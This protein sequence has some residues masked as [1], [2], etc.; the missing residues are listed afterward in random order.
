[1]ET[2]DF[3]EDKPMVEKYNID[4]IPAVAI[5]GE[6]GI[7]YGIR[8][9]GIPAGYEFTSLVEDIVDVSRGTANLPQAVLDELAKVDKPVHLQ[10]MVSP[11]CPYCPKAVRAAHRFAIANPN[12]RSDMV[13]VTEFPHLVQKYDVQG[14]PNTIINEAHKF[15]GAVPELEAIQEMLNAIE[16]K[17]VGSA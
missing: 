9:Y 15:V 13:E 10:V 12:I 8:F 16:I 11:S 17:T 2:Y 3:V 6:G 14:V 7:D 4:K 1:M 5:L